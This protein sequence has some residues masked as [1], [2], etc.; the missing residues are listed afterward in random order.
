MSTKEKLEEK[1]DVIIS[2]NISVKTRDR[3]DRYKE[4]MDVKV[5]RSALIE[6]MI[7]YYI[8]ING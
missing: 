7:N 2:A 5:S 1:K 8:D 4:D 6:Q 3:L